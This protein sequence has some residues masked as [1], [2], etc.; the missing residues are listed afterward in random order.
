[1]L[2]LDDAKIAELK[3]L[4]GSKLRAVECEDGSVLVFKAPSRANYDR[5]VDKKVSAPEAI[6][7]A[8]RELAQSCLVLPTRDEFIKILD[9]TP[10]LLMNE[11]VEAV[12]DMATGNAQVKKL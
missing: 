8:A 12:L 9:A 7:I 3:N 1:M 4:H 2:M 10:G 11:I 5:F 6:S